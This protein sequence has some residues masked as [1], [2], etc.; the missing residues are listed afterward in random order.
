MK[1]FL[2]A[3]VFLISTVAIASPAHDILYKLSEN[4]FYIYLETAKKCSSQLTPIGMA[5][6]LK[7]LESGITNWMKIVL[8][9]VHESNLRYKSGFLSPEIAR[10]RRSDGYWM[11]ITHCYPDHHILVKQ[12]IDLGHLVTEAGSLSGVLLGFTRFGVAL[13]GWSMLYP[14]AAAFLGSSAITLYVKDVNDVIKTEFFTELTPEQQAQVEKIKK[15]VSLFGEVDN[16][17]SEVIEI[18]HASLDSLDKKL[19]DPNLDPTR[20]AALLKKRE[21]ISQSLRLLEERLNQTN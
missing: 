15:S 3:I 21:K 9:D 18:A 14:K 1:L 19:S 6:D 11:A 8:G 12:L 2:P 16:A 7:L 20:K 17:I 5:L 13:D 10:L 4:D